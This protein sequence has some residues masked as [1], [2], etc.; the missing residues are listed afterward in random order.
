[1]SC[2][3]STS[4][5]PAACS[6]L[7]PVLQEVVARQRVGLLRLEQV[8]L[9]DQHVE[10]GAR[11][12][13]QADLR[14]FVRGLRRDQRQ[15]ARFDFADARDH[16]LVGVARVALQRAASAARVRP[17]GRRAWRAP[18]A[19]RDCVAPPAKIGTLRVRPKRARA[20]CV[21]EL[22][23]QAVERC[24]SM[25]PSVRAVAVVAAEVQR[26]LVAG[27]RGADVFF[28]RLAPG[29]SLAVSAGLLSMRH[30]HPLR[31]RR[32]CRAAAAGS[33]PAGP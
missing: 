16:D 5:V 26:R 14:G 1:M 32:W 18:G 8:A 19:R 9:V 29:S 2:T 4:S 6:R 17:G 20:A 3:S 28:G 31:R 22:G 12:D 10:H 33:L 27:A 30:L 7:Q 15:A 11:A 23:R 24:S 21:V 25:S 13:F